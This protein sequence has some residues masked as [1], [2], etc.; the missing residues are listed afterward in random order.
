MYAHAC[1]LVVYTRAYI[2]WLLVQQQCMH[3]PGWLLVFSLGVCVL[4]LLFPSPRDWFQPSFLP[5][6]PPSLPMSSDQACIAAIPLFSSPRLTAYLCSFVLSKLVDSFLSHQCTRT[7]SQSLHGTSY[8]I[9][10][11]CCLLAWYSLLV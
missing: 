11:V 7:A 3:S 6:P 10:F 8:T 2:Q 1:V 4:L 5:L 9:F